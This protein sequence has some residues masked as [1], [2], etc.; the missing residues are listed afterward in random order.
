VSVQY[1]TPLFTSGVFGKKSAQ[2]DLG[3]E[4]VGAGLLRRLIPGVIQNT[5]NAGYYAFYPYLL[6]KWEQL[7]SDIRRDAFVPFYRRHEAAYAVACALHE[8]RGG[9]SLTGINGAIAARQQVR[10]I[11]AG[12]TEV[13]LAAFPAEYMDTPLGGYGL[14]YAAALQEARLVRAGER[15]LVDRTSQ[16]GSAVAHA[17]A[18]T[19]EKTRYFTEFFTAD[20]VP[21]EVL[22][23]LGE[24]TCLCTI[25]GRSDHRLLLDTFFGTELAWPAWEERRRLRVESLSLLLEFHEQRPDGAQDD[26]AAW[27]RALLEARFSDGSAWTTAHPERLESWRAY[28]LREVAVLA[29]TTIWSMY[30]ALL[31]ER[32][33]ATHAELAAEMTSWLDSDRVGFDPQLSLECAMEAAQQRIPTPYQLAEEVEPLLTEWRDEREQA[34]CR[35]VRTLAVIPREVAHHAK[36]FSE[37]LDEGGSHRWSLKHLDGWLNGRADQPFAVAASDLLDALHHQHV[38]VALTKVRVPSAQNLSRYKGN[39][40]D[41]FNFAEDEGVLR[42]L[43]PDEPFWTGARYGVGNHLL[44]TLGLLASPTPP[45]GLTDLGRDFLRTYSDA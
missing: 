13:D 14:F 12:S 38:R 29:L 11:E 28:Q 31:G 30:L 20:A 44:W 16:H 24:S 3:L 32:H 35:A 43:R 1:G 4:E 45:T 21:M 17:F 34:L 39:W 22:R 6:W 2:D 23:E 7:S 8:H 42:P 25:P 10:E 33:R 40:R 37:L 41:P 18:Q 36:G 9:A 5:P 26:L 15:N 19:Y 27:R